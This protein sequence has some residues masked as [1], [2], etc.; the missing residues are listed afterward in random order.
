MPIAEHLCE[1]D[2]V[3][4]L[5]RVPK[6]NK[7]VVDRPMR[8]DVE[9][10]FVNFLDAFRDCFTRRDEHRTENAL[11]RFYAMRRRSVNI[12]RRTCWRNG[13]NFFVASC[14]RTS[15]GTIALSTRLVSSPGGRWS[16]HLFLFLFWLF[17]FPAENSSFLFV[18]FFRRSGD[19]L[20]LGFRCGF[21]L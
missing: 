3:D 8:R 5:S 10:F 19:C 9:I 20:G 6:L 13:D 4:R 21:H 14:R 2:Q 18:S 12:L 7:N 16:R 15:A 11:F 1:C 17:F